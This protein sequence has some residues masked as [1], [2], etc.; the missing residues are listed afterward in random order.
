MKLKT[1]GSV[2]AFAFVATLST[3][4]TAT[5]T[6]SGPTS[7]DFGNYPSGL[8]DTIEAGYYIWSSNEGRD[9]SVRWTGN[10]QGT[11]SSDVWYGTINLMNLENDSLA[12]INF[13]A[14]DGFVDP[15]SENPEGTAFDFISFEAFAGPFWDGFDFSLVSPDSAQVIDFALGTDLWD[16]PES[17][18]N[19]VQGTGIFIGE[20]FA[21]PLVQ[22]QDYNVGDVKRQ[23]QRFEVSQVPEPATLALLGLGLVGLGLR[24]KAKNS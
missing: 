23:V 10:D 9:W 22:I 5:P 16:L 3:G 1:I 7:A 12:P 11:S 17:S 19:D 24:R 4:V 18:R 8:G 20:N 2:A 14:S 6:Y 15:T 21:T 13:E